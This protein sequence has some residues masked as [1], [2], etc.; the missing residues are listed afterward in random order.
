M[1]GAGGIPGTRTNQGS[2]AYGYRPLVPSPGVSAGQALQTN[3]SNLGQIYGLAGGLNQFNQQQMIDQLIAG[4]PGYQENIGAASR[5]TADLL[6]GRIPADVISQMQRAAA[7]RGI[8]APGPNANAAY[9][10]ALGRTSLDLMSQGN[11]ELTEEIGRTPR[12]PL[13]DPSAMFVTPDQ[14]QQA[15]AAAN[16]YAAAPN[17]AAA[18]AERIRIAQTAGLPAAARR[19]TGGFMGVD[20]GAGGPRT[21]YDRPSYQGVVGPVGALPNAITAA[22]ASH[23]SAPPPSAFNPYTTGPGTIGG[24]AY[25]P[26]GIGWM[27]EGGDLNY[28]EIAN[29]M[30]GQNLPY[31][32]Y[33]DLA[34]RGP[35]YPDEEDIYGDLS[36]DEIDSFLEDMGGG[37]EEY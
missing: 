31:G 33:P 6:A 25:P 10:S 29:L 7:E 1:Y 27:P 13:Y 5:N 19:P 22:P 34:G 4:L 15:A 36:P 12:A 21:P 17:P 11:R 35:I 8:F 32:A 3:V 14:V 9:L 20:R 16:L 30:M 24:P 23:W 2:E 37:G 26:P 18:A 28:D